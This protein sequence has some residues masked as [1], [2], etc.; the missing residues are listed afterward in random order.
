MKNFFYFLF[1]SLCFS[2]GHQQKKQ[3]QKETDSLC[4]LI[5]AEEFPPRP[6]ILLVAKKQPVDSLDVLVKKADETDLG[7]L[8]GDNFHLLT[9]KEFQ[10]AKNMV[11]SFFEKKEYRGKTREKPYPFNHYFRQYVGYKKNN[12]IMVFV[13]LCTSWPSYTGS[14]SEMETCIV[15]TSDGGPHYGDMKID[16]TDNKIVSFGLNSYV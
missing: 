10:Q 1:L 6:E 2:C 13:I 9:E 16:L 3:D 11:A 12:H 15:T 4:A 5:E 8:T 14:V 7:V